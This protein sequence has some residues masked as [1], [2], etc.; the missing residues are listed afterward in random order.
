M[1]VQIL[2]LHYTIE[3]LCVIVTKIKAEMEENSIPITPCSRKAFLK[4]KQ[5]Y[6]ILE[7]WK[8][9]IKMRKHEL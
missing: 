4:I 3:V 1:Q 9:G 5:Y 8:D 6:Q 2:F 7:N